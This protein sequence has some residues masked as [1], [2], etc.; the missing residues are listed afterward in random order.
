MRRTR[1]D[2]VRKVKVPT[3]SGGY[4]V[5]KIKDHRLVGHNLFR[6]PDKCSGSWPYEL[7]V[8]GQRSTGRIFCTAGF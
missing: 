6:T 1:E 5:R 4:E 3:A 2:F 8:A 7:S